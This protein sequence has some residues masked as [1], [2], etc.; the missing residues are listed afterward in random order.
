M[1]SVVM[2]IAVLA[3]I[4]IASDIF[5]SPSYANRDGL[6]YFMSIVGA[7]FALLCIA[8]AVFVVS[9]MYWFLRMVNSPKEGVTIL[10]SGMFKGRAV[11]SSAYLSR[12]GLEARY[13][14]LVAARR[15]LECW[16][17]ATLLVATMYGVN[18]WIYRI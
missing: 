14:L 9:A 18:L 16:L 3:F 15:F 6:R 2:V 7:A 8:G 4:A 17:G 10:D 5:R 1:R 11:F 12:S 13:C